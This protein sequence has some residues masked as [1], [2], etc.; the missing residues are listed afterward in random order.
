MRRLN[1]SNL[2]F[3]AVT[4][5]FMLAAGSRSAAE[6]VFYRLRRKS[7]AL[8]HVFQCGTNPTGK[9]GDSSSGRATRPSTTAPSSVTKRSVPPP[10]MMKTG[11]GS[12]GML[13]P[14]VV[15][16]QSI[17][18]PHPLHTLISCTPFP[19]TGRIPRP[20]LRPNALFTVAAST[21]APLYQ[22]PPFACCLI[23]V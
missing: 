4:L 20:R 8:G 2:R 1:P 11:S 15:R 18:A 3:H 5:P 14:S 17:G 10:S 13:R 19:A 23:V 6:I 7:P 12:I 21:L 9:A 16:I 22:I